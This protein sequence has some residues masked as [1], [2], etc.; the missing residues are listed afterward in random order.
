MSCV[1]CQCTSHVNYIVEI[2][3]IHLFI[4][5]TLSIQ[6]INMFLYKLNEEVTPDELCVRGKYYS[7]HN[8]IEKYCLLSFLQ[9]LLLI[10]TC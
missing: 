8:V 9:G 1:G 6:D 2:E 5:V 10:L 4:C 7:S 3:A